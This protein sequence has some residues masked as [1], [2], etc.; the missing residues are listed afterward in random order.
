MKTHYIK[1]TYKI[2]ICALKLNL[3]G[4]D[5]SNDLKDCTLCD[6]NAV[7]DEYN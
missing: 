6:S 2:I 1:E 5:I 7:E 4:I 3:A